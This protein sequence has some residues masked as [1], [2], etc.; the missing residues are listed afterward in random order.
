[1]RC[2]RVNLSNHQTS[3]VLFE[4][5]GQ[6]TEPITTPYIMAI[7]AISPL[8]P[9]ACCEAAILNAIGHRLRMTPITPSS[10]R[11][12]ERNMDFQYRHFG[13]YYFDM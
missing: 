7:R 6:V 12:S 8:L 5:G 3:F 10:T 1:M 4:I 9:L 2:S 13:D 11:T